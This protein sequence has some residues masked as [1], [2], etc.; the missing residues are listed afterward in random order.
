MHGLHLI[1][2]RKLLVSLF[3][4]HAKNMKVAITGACGHIGIS[5]IEELDRR[6]IQ[7]KALAYNDSKYLESK[8]IEF[9]TGNV[10]N[11]ED[12]EK[13]LQGCD[14]L[15][16]SAAIISINGDKGGTVRKV[17]VDGV[18]N[19]MQTALDLK[20]KRVVHISSIHAYNALP[21]NEV[22]DENRNF[23]DE[24]AFAYDQSKRDGQLVVKEMVSKGLN[25]IV[26]NPTSVTGAPENKL[27]YQG[28]AILDIYNNKIPAIFKGG[29]DWVD[30]RDI[31][32]SVCNALTMGRVGEN[33]LLSGKYY[34][35]RDIINIV[36]EVKGMKIKIP[37]IPVWGARAGLPFVKLGSKITGKEP[38]Y[39]AESI[40]VL[41][42]GNEKISHEKAKNELGYQPEFGFDHYLEKTVIWYK[43]NQDWWKNVKT[44]AYQ[45]YYK[46]QYGNS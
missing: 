43:E 32:N 26:L 13:L 17:N 39:T 23:V 42:H 31:A 37:T 21:K 3:F 8:G 25:A 7:Y 24:T 9:V 2:N 19:V 28:K 10:N 11:R 41:V 14:A 45:E 18:R 29:F 20:I 33:Y 36:T 12:I 27:S 6:G 40:D 34:T 35:M 30:V 46:R 5:I 16:H 15:I 22:L 4:Q 1:E 38:L 44:G